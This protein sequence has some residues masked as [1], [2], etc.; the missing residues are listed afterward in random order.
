MKTLMNLK[1]DNVQW[2]TGTITII[3]E[4]KQ[5]CNMTVFKRQ[6]LNNQ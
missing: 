3:L 6:V 1:L 5:N 2:M 4:M